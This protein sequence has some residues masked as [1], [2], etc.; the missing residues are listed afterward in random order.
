MHYRVV[1]TWWSG[2]SK[3]TFSTRDIF[4]AARLIKI[5]RKEVYRSC[6]RM[7]FWGFEVYSLEWGYVACQIRL[8]P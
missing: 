4:P 1:S 5:D 7:R 8:Q 2:Q 3:T 6:S